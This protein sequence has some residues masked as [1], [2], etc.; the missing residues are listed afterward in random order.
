VE[1]LRDNLAGGRGRLPDAK[2]REEI[3]RVFA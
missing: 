2:Q 1:H 3:A